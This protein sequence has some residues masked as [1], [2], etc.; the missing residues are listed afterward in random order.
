[1]PEMFNATRATI[2]LES[3]YNK[4]VYDM[5]LERH[6]LT[7]LQHEALQEMRKVGETFEVNVLPEGDTVSLFSSEWSLFAG[8]KAQ[9]MNNL[10]DCPMIV[11]VEYME[12]FLGIT[13][14]ADEDELLYITFEAY[15]P[16][17]YENVKENVFYK[18]LRSC[19]KSIM[20]DIRHV[21][22]QKVILLKDADLDAFLNYIEHSNA[23]GELITY[24]QEEE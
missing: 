24:A 10:P 19:Q 13:K 15:R 8:T 16:R 22:R 6:S 20:A 14:A 4:Y 1:M 9:I 5:D 23:E 7:L 12:Q 2:T 18:A 21:S 3:N 11:M 17:D